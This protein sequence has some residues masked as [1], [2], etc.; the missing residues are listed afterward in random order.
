MTD[1]AKRGFR[2]KLSHAGRAGKH[3]Y[4]FVNP[5]LLRGSTV[6]VPTVADRRALQA[7]RDE[8]VLSYGLGGSQT[9]W[10]LEDMI[11]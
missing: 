1:T 2:T 6:L 5:P 3:T 10:A 7:K 8:R 9:H 11:A 4:G